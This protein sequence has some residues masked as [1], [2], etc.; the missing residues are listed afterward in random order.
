MNQPN[1]HTPAPDTLFSDHAPAGAPPR[2]PHS[3]TIPALGE[4]NWADLYGQLNDEG[5]AV[6]PPLLSREQCQEIIDTFEE[7]GL[8]RST[9]VM[10]RHQFGRGTYK[11]YA[12]PAAVPLVQTL[13]ER[14]YPPMAWIA[15]QWAP[16]LGE[17]TFPGTLDEL[18]DECADNGQKRP[19]PLIL[20]YG[21]GDYACLHQDIYGDI[22]FPLQ[23]AVM[24]NQPGEDF[25]GGENVFVEQR[26]RFQSRA[27]VV[28]PRLG[29]GMI[30]PVR[31]RPVRGKNGFRR[32]P[33]RHGTNAVESGHRNTLGL[34][35][36][37]AR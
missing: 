5:V 16:Q 6:T 15:N 7:P 22:V 19:T 11:Y 2:I 35:F 24:L 34:I 20:Q 26:P 21:E 23:I 32:H 9:V 12:D 3:R 17:R 14:L 18:I 28:K 36:H 4:L 33:M 25:T 10:Q 27:M 30:F 13:R 31:H 8:F 29:Q 1:Q 37:N